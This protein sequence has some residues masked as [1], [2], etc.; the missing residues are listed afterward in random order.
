[1]T[2]GRG[3]ENP[4]EEISMSNLLVAVRSY[5]SIP[6]VEDSQKSVAA[7]AHRDTHFIFAALGVYLCYFYYGYLQE[8]MYVKS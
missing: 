4:S 3:C 2:Q 5:A 6:S 1:M 7:R 8:R